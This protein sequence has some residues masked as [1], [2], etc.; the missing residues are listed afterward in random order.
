M[1][2]AIWYEGLTLRS[3]LLRNFKSVHYAEVELAPLT[4]IVGANSAGKSTLLQ[5]IRVAA[6][7]ANTE[8][9]FFPLNAEQIRLGTFEETRFSGVDDP[10]ETIGIGGRFQLGSPTYFAPTYGRYPNVRR[11]PRRSRDIT[12]DTHLDW[13]LELLGTPQG[14][15]ASTNIVGV[16]AVA[17]IGDNPPA[18]LRAERAPASSNVPSFGHQVRYEGF[19]D[20]ADGLA[21]EVVDVNVVG[22][23]PRSYLYTEPLEDLL[24]WTWYDVRQAM[25]RATLP[26]GGAAHSERRRLTVETET[27]KAS[28]QDV[29][30][31]VELI[32]SDLRTL[33]DEMPRELLQSPSAQRAIYIRLRE[34]YTSRPTR[35]ERDWSR[36]QLEQIYH[37]VTDALRLGGQDG[38]RIEGLPEVLDDAVE[39]AC[40]FLATRVQ[41]LGPLR[42]DPQVVYHSSPAAHPGFIGAK[43]EY[44]ASVLQTSGHQPVLNPPMVPGTGP[45]YQTLLAAVN[46][47][48]AYLGIGDAFRTKDLGRLGLQLSVRQSGVNMDLDLTSVGTGVSQ[49]LPVLVMC[50][51]APP[52]SLLLIEQPELHLNPAVQQR[53]ADFLLAVAA[54][55]RQLVVETHSDYLVTRLRRRTAE[56][57]TGQTRSRIALV[58]AERSD[59]ATTYTKVTPAADGSMAD[60][61]A[62]FF[63]EAAEDSQALLEALLESREK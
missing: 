14:Q 61:P 8:S 24:F 38:P 2:D 30:E 19:V 31:I 23:F 9:E 40:D 56:D 35:P 42:M 39:E 63:D 49:I 51:Q 21:V 46:E 43:G 58:F 27:E 37:S 57:L 60:W 10:D 17:R 48:S 5:S 18:T 16:S 12:D 4:V 26:R 54:T 11:R 59:G 22:G 6:Q 1:P 3:W 36:V 45:R 32:S 25:M 47:W 15:S 7:A 52:G 33:L 13:K 44:S 50:L 53:L 55:G 34:M 20:S 62:G 41:H 29:N 28:A